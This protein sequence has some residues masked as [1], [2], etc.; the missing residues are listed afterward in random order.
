MAMSENFVTS[1]ASYA[2]RLAGPWLVAIFLNA[3]AAGA[4]PA[5]QPGVSASTDS[6]ISEADRRFWSF[7]PLSR[8]DVPRPR[9]RFALAYAD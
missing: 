1:Y 9:R 2:R 4:E 3:L 5:A 7:R 8:P 6:P